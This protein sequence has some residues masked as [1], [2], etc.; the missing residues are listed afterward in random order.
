MNLTLTS[1]PSTSSAS[2]SPAT[3]LA[4]SPATEPFDEFKLDDRQLA[5]KLQELRT[6][7]YFTLPIAA[8]TMRFLEAQAA[9]MPH[10]PLVT[11]RCDLRGSTYELTATAF[12]TRVLAH[13]VPATLTLQPNEFEIRQ[14]HAQVATGWHED[15][16]PK[17]LS[18]ITT[19]VGSG[20]QFLAPDVSVTRFRTTVHYGLQTGAKLVRL[21]DHAVIEPHVQTMESGKI[22]V[23]VGRGL[24]NSQVPVLVHRSPGEVGRTIFMARWKLRQPAAGTPDSPTLLPGLSRE[25][26]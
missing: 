7:G 14:P 18:C 24:K 20:T 12:A 8:P 26:A 5:S 17:L 2:V 13:L 11:N 6:H 21:A 25:A 19:L 22:Y 1:A 9:L 15:N 16:A 3:A 4:K 23:F 10:D